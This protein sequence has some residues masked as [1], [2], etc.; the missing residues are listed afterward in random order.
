MAAKLS[1]GQ[2][3]LEIV[4][5]LIKRS[6]EGWCASL[7]GAHQSTLSNCV[8][9]FSSA[10]PAWS[11]FPSE[12]FAASLT[13]S[14]PVG[15]RSRMRSTSLLTALPTAHGIKCRSLPP[16]NYGHRAKP[17]QKGSAWANEH[18]IVV[19]MKSKRLLS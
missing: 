9:P 2:R 11:T 15:I 19:R 17:C 1:M 12:T 4:Q 14:P 5:I 7:E 13:D 18:S 16:L 6:R 8:I 3:P 10:W